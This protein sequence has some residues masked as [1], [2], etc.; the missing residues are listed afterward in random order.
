MAFVYFQHLPLELQA[1]ILSIHDCIV[2]QCRYVSKN[3][4]ILTQNRYDILSNITVSPIK[5]AEIKT[6]VSNGVINFTIIDGNTHALSIY[7]YH[8]R[9]EQDEN[10]IDLRYIVSETD[11]PW[12]G[13]H[14]D[15]Y[16]CYGPME[17]CQNFNVN[18]LYKNNTKR[19]IDLLSQYY[20]YA[21]RYSIDIKCHFSKQK[22]L[23]ILKETLSNANFGD[24]Q[25]LVWIYYY[26]LGNIN[27]F[28]IEV[29]ARYYS[30][31]TIYQIKKDIP[32]LYKVL[33]TAINN[34]K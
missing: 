13:D 34:L 23:R 25:E 24:N 21:T 22:V 33:L 3:F 1:S 9:N 10:D 31:K 19:F 26:L 17:Y 28:C 7:E 30:I 32:E 11:I 12:I 29:I 18:D 8:L 2:I 5:C 15:L 20:I 6:Y 4:A 14:N 27:A 16:R